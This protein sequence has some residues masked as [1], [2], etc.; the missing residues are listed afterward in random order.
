MHDVNYHGIKDIS[1][2]GGSLLLSEFAENLPQ[3]FCGSCS[4]GTISQGGASGQG[5]KERALLVQK[6][7]ASGGLP[8]SVW[9]SNGCKVV[10]SPL[11][12]LCPD[13]EKKTAVPQIQRWY[14][15]KHNIR[16]ADQQIYF[17]DD[18]KDNIHSF[19]GLPY[20]AQQISCD[21]RDERGAL[22]FCGATVAE[23]QRRQGVHFCQDHSS[24]IF[25]V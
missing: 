15:E 13:G 17:F 10:D 5:S 25:V 14:L 21:P 24:N 7:N 2:G 12:T 23:I 6:L 8:T 19:V 11:V 18:R 20:N 16:I 1:Y 22:G 9:N 4:I 3:T